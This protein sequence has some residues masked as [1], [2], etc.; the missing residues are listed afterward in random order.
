MINYKIIADSIDFYSKFGFKRIE[1]PW[2]V[3]EAVDD[4]TKPSER[5]HMQLKHN[6]KCLVAS[7]E[8]S[9]LYLYCKDFLPL[10]KY[11]TVTPC[12]R[13]EQFDGMHMKNFIKNE[14]IITDDVTEKQLNIMV[15]AALE[16]FSQYVDCHIEK[17]DEGY[18]IISD[19]G[20]ELGS[21]GIRSCDYLKWIYGTGV[22]EP[23]LSRVMQS[24]NNQ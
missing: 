15:G 4:I 17:T 16:F 13:Y 6:D 12:F 2:T 3:S 1:A 19:N 9:F 14:L 7:G 8:Q 23:R 21:Y 5:I 24:L 11:Q 20:Y 10:G 18:D 22:A